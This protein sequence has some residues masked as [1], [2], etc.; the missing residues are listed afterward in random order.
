MEALKEQNVK[1]WN[2]SMLDDDFAWENAC[3]KIRKEEK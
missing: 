3:E 1:D 2:F